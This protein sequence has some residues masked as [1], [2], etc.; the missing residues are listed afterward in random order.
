MLIFGAE[1]KFISFC[2]SCWILIL[3]TCVHGSAPWYLGFPSEIDSS[4]GCW[5]LHVY[6]LYI[7]DTFRCFMYICD[8]YIY[9]Y[10]VFIYMIINGEI[11]CLKCGSIL[12]WLSTE[13][14]KQRKSHPQLSGTSTTS[15][16]T[17]GYIYRYT[18][19]HIS[20]HPIGNYTNIPL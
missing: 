9:I 4:S 19:S 8:I 17:G 10:T 13:C 20:H 14:K 18:I 2:V 3:V 15:S 11:I 6:T 12:R 5:P 16:Q 1:N 7:N